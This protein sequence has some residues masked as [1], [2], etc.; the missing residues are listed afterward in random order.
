MGNRGSKK[1]GPDEAANEETMPDSTVD[2]SESVFK[3]CGQ[4]KYSR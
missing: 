2:E 3:V 4:V 1:K